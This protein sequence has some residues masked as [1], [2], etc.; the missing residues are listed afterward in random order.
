MNG[1][2]GQKDVSE[3]G[4]GQCA[5]GGASATGRSAR[6]RSL[7]SCRLCSRQ[8]CGRLSSPREHGRFDVGYQDRLA[9]ADACRGLAPTG[10][11]GAA[12]PLTASCTGRATRILGRWVQPFRPFAVPG[13]KALH[14]WTVKLC[15]ALAFARRRL[16]TSGVARCSRRTGARRAHLAHETLE[17]LLRWRAGHADSRCLRARELLR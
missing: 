17:T 11:S 14:A 12:R 2:R 4:H 1:P 7:A 8:Y 3:A 9:C 13:V 5:A 6:C 16:R 10:E 15:G